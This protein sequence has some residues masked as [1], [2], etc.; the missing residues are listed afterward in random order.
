MWH[1]LCFDY[2]ME[3]RSELADSF[4]QGQVGMHSDIECIDM[5]IVVESMVAN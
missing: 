5:V 4:E 2:A 1:E 3:A